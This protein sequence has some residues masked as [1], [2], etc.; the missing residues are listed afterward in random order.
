MGVGVASA[1]P[2]LEDRDCCYGVDE[3]EPSDKEETETNRQ[4]G[5]NTSGGS[6]SERALTDAC[7]R[8]L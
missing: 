7:G 8:A 3:Q 5:E 4:K 1:A 2:I 6:D